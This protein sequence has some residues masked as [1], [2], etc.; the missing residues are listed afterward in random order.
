MTDRKKDRKTDR[1]KE[2]Q[3]DRERQT[4]KENKDG[5]KKIKNFLLF[6][7]PEFATPKSAT[8]ISNWTRWKRLTRRSIGSSEFTKSKTWTTEATES[9]SRGEVEKE[10][11]GVRRTL[12]IAC[13][14]KAP[15]FSAGCVSQIYILYVYLFSSVRGGGVKTEK[16]LFSCFVGS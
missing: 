11:N 3:K 15:S 2:R 7:L 16:G 1:Q 10:C 8:K 4:Q 6:S 13:L 12:Y 14:S 5:W 9:V